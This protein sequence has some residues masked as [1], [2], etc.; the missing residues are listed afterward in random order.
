MKTI[1]KQSWKYGYTTL[2]VNGEIFVIN[3]STDT[4]KW[5]LSNETTG[6]LVDATN[7]KKEAMD[8][9]KDLSNQ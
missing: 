7:T 2:E 9:L 3:Q 1:S 8:Y 6:E 4:N 5:L